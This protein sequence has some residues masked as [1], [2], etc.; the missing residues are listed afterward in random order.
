MNVA[1]TLIMPLGMAL[2]G[3]LA[4]AVPIQ[5]LMVGSGIGQAAVAAAIYFWKRYYSQGVPGANPPDN[6]LP[7]TESAQ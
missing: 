4:D 5:W 2:F 1:M 3:P 6:G 7:I